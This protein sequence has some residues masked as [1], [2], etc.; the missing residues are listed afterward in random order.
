MQFREKV[1]GEIETAAE[2]LGFRRRG[3]Y[4]RVAEE[5]SRYCPRS[6]RP[7]LST[8]GAARARFLAVTNLHLLMM[9][10]RNIDQ[11]IGRLRKDLVERA[12]RTRK[13]VARAAA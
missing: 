11:E 13:L 5:V 4:V 2:A 1:A 3:L 12:K 8:E 10:E 7:S 6:G 9:A